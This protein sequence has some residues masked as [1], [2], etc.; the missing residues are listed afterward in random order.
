M[1]LKS[2]MSNIL[3]YLESYSQNH[4][5][6]KN[7][8]S[9]NSEVFCF[10]VSGKFGDNELSG[11]GQSYNKDKSFL[12]AV[13]ELLERFIVNQFSVEGKIKKGLFKKSEFKYY[14]VTSTNGVA[15]HFSRKEAISNALDELIERHIVLKALA[16]NISPLKLIGLTE[17][18]EKQTKYPLDFYT[19]LGP[20][21]RN[22][23][24]ARARHKGHTIYG[25][26][27][28]KNLNKSLGKSF[29][30]LYP[31]LSLFEDFADT[32]RSFIN[33]NEHTLFH[34]E[35]STDWTNNFFEK[36]KNIIVPPKIDV[37]IN[38]SE[39]IADDF[40]LC[41]N[42]KKIGVSAVVLRCAKF[43]QLFSGSWS[44]SKINMRAISTANLP[45]EVHMIG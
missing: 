30:E 11:F 34:W 37:G 41:N 3:S 39:L 20:Y 12:I 31:R 32:K 21:K 35:G 4:L 9:E 18:F 25:F 29:L 43:Q 26:G 28:N 14:K 17:S 2:K 24:V 38:K 33:N 27:C 6:M 40:I 36:S 42:L 13:M 1:N 5:N 45:P 15:V 19:W 23:V 16:E 22:V 8:T 10:A 44:N 7:L